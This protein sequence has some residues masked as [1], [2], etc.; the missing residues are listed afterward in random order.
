LG[1]AEAE[2]EAEAEAEAET[3]AAHAQSHP[4][5]PRRPD[6]LVHHDIDETAESIVLDPQSD[7]A[8]VLNA[9]AGAVWLLCDGTRTADQICQLLEEHWADAGLS[10]EQVRRDVDRV[11]EQFEQEGLIEP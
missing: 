9:V 8:T 10:H 11:L 5:R 2:V 4:L 1:E 3:A 7:K 6:R